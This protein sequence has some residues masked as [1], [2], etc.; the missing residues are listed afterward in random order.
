MSRGAGLEVFGALDVC[1]AQRRVRRLARTAGLGDDATFQ[2]LIAV[3]ELANHLFV[4]SRR[5]GALAFRVLRRGD[6][7]G[8]EVLARVATGGQWAVDLPPIEPLVDEFDAGFEGFGR[9]YVRARKWTSAAG[10]SA[11]F[12]ARAPGRPVA[13]AGR[14]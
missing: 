11:V 8:L 14:A 12:A 1:E 10:A 13:A 6:R 4:A 7:R 3:T 2:L 9:I 5:T